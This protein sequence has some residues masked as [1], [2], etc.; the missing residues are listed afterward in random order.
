MW[1]SEDADHPG[2]PGRSH[3]QRHHTALQLGLLPQSPRRPQAPPAYLTGAAQCY[4]VSQVKAA[5]THTHTHICPQAKGLLLFSCVSWCCWFAGMSPPHCVRESECCLFWMFTAVWLQMHIFTNYEHSAQLFL[6]F[7][8]SH[9]HLSPLTCAGNHSNSSKCIFFVCQDF[10]RSMD[11]LD[12]FVDHCGFVVHSNLIY[13]PVQW[14][15]NSTSMS[16]SYI[17]TS[18]HVTSATPDEPGK[19]HSVHSVIVIN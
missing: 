19:L 9:L 6:S 14:T 13:Q 17:T 18:A 2:R 12:G 3:Q 1:C 5:R 15:Y 16:V 4:R 10:R 8:L 7:P 11:D